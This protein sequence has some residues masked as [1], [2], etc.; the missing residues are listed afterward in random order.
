MNGS[1]Q[2]LNANH[3]NSAC[4]LSRRFNLPEVHWRSPVD[5][6][7]SPDRNARRAMVA[8]TPVSQA[9]TAT[10]SCML[11][12]LSRG[13]IPRSA[14]TFICSSAPKID[15]RSSRRCMRGASSHSG[16]DLP[17]SS[18]RSFAKCGSS[19][20]PGSSFEGSQNYRMAFLATAVLIVIV[21]P[22]WRIQH[23][24]IFG[25]L[26]HGSL[27]GGSFGNYCICAVLPQSQG[28][29]TADF[30]ERVVR[31]SLDGSR[32]VCFYSCAS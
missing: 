26:G 2:I 12:R 32:Q 31:S 1:I 27:P 30:G 5:E 4:R 10:R 18:S 9:L 11:F 23:F 25:R 3:R 7:H 28:G 6:I 29:G 22:L 16:C 13:L 19:Q 24:S 14:P 17:K 21:W 15:L 8:H 20:R